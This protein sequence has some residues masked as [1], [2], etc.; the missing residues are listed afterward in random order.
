MCVLFSCA[1]VSFLQLRSLVMLLLSRFFCHASSVT[2][3]QS[4]FF[5]HASSVTLL[6]SRFFG[7]A[8][9]VMFLCITCLQATFLYFTVCWEVNFVISFLISF[10]STFLESVAR[11]KTWFVCF[12]I[13]AWVSLLCQCLSNSLVSSLC[14]FLCQFFGSVP[15]VSSLSQLLD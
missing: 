1:G 14:W 11:K 2:L 9:S 12:V 15:W 8:S 6:R 4:C 13:I 3:L 7:H 5:S 10:L